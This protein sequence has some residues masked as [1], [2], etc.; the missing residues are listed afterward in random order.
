MRSVTDLSSS[1]KCI[2]QTFSV[3]SAIV[4]SFPPSVF[5]S[6]VNRQTK[7]KKKTLSL[8]WKISLPSGG[9]QK[10]K[11]HSQGEM[12][13]TR[14]QRSKTFLEEHCQKQ[15]TE[16][17]GA[18]LSWNSSRAPTEWSA[19]FAFGVYTQQTNIGRQLVRNSA[20]HRH[21]FTAERRSFLT[22]NDKPSFSLL[23]HHIPSW[24]QTYLGENNCIQQ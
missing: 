4:N 18:S 8:L 11:T 6:E 7:R 1:L 19:I 22:R 9:I 2:E 3:P 14:S 23:L 21:S 13:Q 16:A 20:I 12:K 24:L 5:S 17:S 15:N 10:H